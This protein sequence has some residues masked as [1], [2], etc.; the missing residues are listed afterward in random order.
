MFFGNFVKHIQTRKQLEFENFQRLSILHSSWMRPI[1]RMLLLFTLSKSLCL[2]TV[3][4]KSIKVQQIQS[5]LIKLKPRDEIFGEM[6]N[7][8]SRLSWIFIVWFKLVYWY[9]YP[10]LSKYWVIYICISCFVK[11][12][13]HHQL[14]VSGVN[15]LMYWLSYFIG[16]VLKFILPLIV[17]FICLAVANNKS[18]NMSWSFLGLVFLAFILHVPGNLLFVYTFSIVFKNSRIMKNIGYLILNVVS[19][20]L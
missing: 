3:H 4:R 19:F 13:I 12:G 9:I 7:G 11:D 16:D 1:F 5:K 15:R 10:T 17:L 8:Q 6:A 18:L 2:A 14:R 20:F